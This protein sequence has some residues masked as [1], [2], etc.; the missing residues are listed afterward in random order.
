M[1]VVAL[2][3]A[4]LLA[5][6]QAA[7]ERQA[8]PL[9]AGPEVLNVEMTEYRFDYDGAVTAGR[10]LLRVRN[11]GRVPHSLTMF[12]LDEDLPPIDEQMRGSERRSI[13][14]FAGIRAQQ[15]GASTTFAVDLAPGVRYALVCFLPDAEGKAHALR[16]M[17]SEFR[18]TG[19][20]TG[21]RAP[22]STGTSPSTG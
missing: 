11:T 18:A 7:P 8:V 12:P 4:L 15:P 14:P 5:S 13:T 17:N 20:R 1:P 19:T 10:V 22:A 9:P 21:E 16:G 2:A 3:S 6:C